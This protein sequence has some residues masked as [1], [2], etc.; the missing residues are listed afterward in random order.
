VGDDDDAALARGAEQVGD[1]PVGERRVERGVGLVA[2]QDRDLGEQRPCER[3]PLALPAG[4]GAAVLAD[5]S[6]EPAR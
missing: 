3:E 6:G 2:E 5:R 1:E 4:E